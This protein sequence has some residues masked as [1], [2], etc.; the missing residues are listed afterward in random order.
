MGNP[1]MEIPAQSQTTSFLV[2]RVTGTCFCSTATF[3]RDTQLRSNTQ[4]TTLLCRM[5][6]PVR[7]SRF[8]V[9]YQTLSEERQERLGCR[10]PKARTVSFLTAILCRSPSFST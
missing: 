4:I 5:I 3:Q 1:P 2:P 10:Y 9:L 7:C 8:R 6:L